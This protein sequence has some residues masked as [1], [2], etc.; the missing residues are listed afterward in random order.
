MISWTYA[1]HEHY[2]R[3]GMKIEGDDGRTLLI[4]QMLKRADC[5]LSV[6][7]KKNIDAINTVRHE[8]EH[9]ILGVA[10]SSGLAFFRH[11]A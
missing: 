7:V 9:K 4:S 1:L 8:V 5:P 6:A 11:A 2:L 3:S 10:T